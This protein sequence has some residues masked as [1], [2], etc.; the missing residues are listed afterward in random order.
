MRERLGGNRV[1]VQ[2]QN[3]QMTLSV[4]IPKSLADNYGLKIGDKC[5]WS[6]A[7][8]SDL[9]KVL[10]LKKIEDGPGMAV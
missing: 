9:S 6:A 8:M 7:Q 3:L 1:K 10:A 4:V 5:E 2:R